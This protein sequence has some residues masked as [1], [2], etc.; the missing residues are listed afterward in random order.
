MVFISY[1]LTDPVKPELFCKQRHFL[2]R[3]GVKKKKH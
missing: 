1:V 2:L 3:E